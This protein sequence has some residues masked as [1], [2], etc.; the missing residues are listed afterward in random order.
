MQWKTGIGSRVGRGTGKLV[1]R[2]LRSRR[3]AFAFGGTGPWETSPQSQIQN[4]ERP[5]ARPSGVSTCSN[6]ETGCTLGSV[7][8]MGDPYFGRTYSFC[9][10]QMFSETSNLVGG[11]KPFKVYS[12]SKP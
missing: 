9:S 4:R 11:T 8:E 7:E 2:R 6:L 5:A 1:F 10:C 3:T 12:Y